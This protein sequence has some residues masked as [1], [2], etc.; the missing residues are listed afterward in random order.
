MSGLNPLP[1]L[2]P[3][4]DDRNISLLWVQGRHLLHES[5]TSCFQ[6]R[7]GA[8]KMLCYICSLFSVFSSKSS[9]CS[10]HIVGCCLLLTVELCLCFWAFKAP[11]WCQLNQFSTQ[12]LLVPVCCLAHYFCVFCSTPAGKWDL[13]EQE[14]CVSCGVPPGTELC[15]PAVGTDKY[16]WEGGMHFITTVSSSKAGAVSLLF[17]PISLVPNLVLW[18][19]YSVTKMHML[20]PN[21]HSDYIM[22]GVLER[23]LGLEGGAPGMGLVPL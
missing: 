21:P 19:E 14:H 5:F 11:L 8:F 2:S 15:V 13:W 9:M 23:W 3:I 22:G 12:Q 7:K 10:C 6:G 16:L 17:I 20:N 1:S 18:S 4:L